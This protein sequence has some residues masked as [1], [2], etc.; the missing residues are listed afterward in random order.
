MSTCPRSG[1]DCAAQGRKLPAMRS[2]VSTVAVLC[3]GLSLVAQTAPPPTFEV[4][5]IKLNKTQSRRSIGGSGGRWTMTNVAIEGLILS[6]YPPTPMMDDAVQGAPDWVMSD[7]YDV[8]AKA[9]F[10][11]T[12]EQERLMLRA[13]LAERFNFKAHY[14]THERPVYNLV[15]ARADGRLGPQLH[16]IDLDCETYKADPN[17]LQEWTPDKVPPCAFSISGGNATKMVSGGR[18]MQ[19]LADSVSGE[20]GRPVFDKTGL[21]GYY[22]FT[23]ESGGFD[24]NGLSVFTSLQEQLGLKLESA[25]GAVQILVI[26]HIERPT[27]D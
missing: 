24:P 1:C 18:T 5:S 12:K 4:A 25:R 22:A 2:A 7:R 19:Q 6:A 10:V 9:A 17:A 27:E 23:L 11:P 15:V 3:C 20:A 21:N 13:L 14:E 8:E 26:E 16:H